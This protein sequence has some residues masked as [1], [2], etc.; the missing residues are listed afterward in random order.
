[1][2]TVHIYYIYYIRFF[3]N[4]KKKNADGVQ[5]VIFAVSFIFKFVYQNTNKRISKSTR[6]RANF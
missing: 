5:N 6:S 2:Q 3:F 4:L 1:M